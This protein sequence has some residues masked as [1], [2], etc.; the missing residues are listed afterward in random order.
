MSKKKNRLTGPKTKKCPARLQSATHW[1]PTY[2][3]KHIVRG[4]RK[5]FRVDVICAI[6]ELRMLGVRLDE[7][8]V[9]QLIRKR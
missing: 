7:S 2:T 1:I 3:G 8:Y 9:A 5:R 6:Q 4:Y